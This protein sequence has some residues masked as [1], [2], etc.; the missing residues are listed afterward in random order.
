MYVLV[1]Y[2]ATLTLP[3]LTLND[4]YYKYLEMQNP[5]KKLKIPKITTFKNGRGF[6][7]ESKVCNEDCN[8]QSNDDD[9]CRNTNLAM[10]DFY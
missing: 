4:G 5:Q 8:E 10:S 7:S 9:N 2:K 6:A 1:W 3:L